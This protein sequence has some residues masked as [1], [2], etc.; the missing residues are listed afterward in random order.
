[1]RSL[2][3]LCL[4]AGSAA[5]DNR[6]DADKAFNEG[7]D[8]LVN[9]KDAKGA[10]DKFEQAITLDPT[11]P[12]VMLNLGLCNEMQERFSTALYWFR[13][14]Q[15]A[16]AEAKPPLVDY[17]KAA[18]EHTQA[19]A[20]KIAVGRVLDTDKYPGITITVDGRPVRPDEYNHLELDTQS[21]IEAHAPGKLT[22]TQ[23]VEV[24]GRTAKD[25]TIVM[26]DEPIPPMRD[27]GKGRRRLAYIVG[28]GGVVLWGVTLWYGLAVRDTADEDYDKAKRELRY[29]DTGL[30]IAGTAAVGAAVVL[31]LT[32]PKPYR[33]RREAVITPI[34]TPDQVGVGYSRAF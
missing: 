33:E 15:A 25:I 32:A 4:L 17:Q 13:R 3:V 10:C 27:P 24:D 30:F 23:K 18:E 16:A 19:L 29:Y 28:A 9:K 26:K 7:R 14:A 22:F 6:S 1:M 5:A 31:Y 21:V 20:D 2:V 8:L 34:V 11:A 12:G